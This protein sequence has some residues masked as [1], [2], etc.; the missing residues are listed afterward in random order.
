[1]NKEPLH[2]C[3][4]IDAFDGYL[5]GASV[6][7]QR[8]VE[9]LRL[10]GHRVSVVAAGKPA[11]DKT[12][13]AEYYPPMGRKHMHFPFGKPNDKVLSEVISQVDIVHVQLPFKLSKHAIRI[14][15]QKAKPCV[16]SFHVQAENYLYPFR[17]TAAWL[18]KLVYHYQIHTI[19]NRVDHVIC[20]SELGRQELNRHGLAKPATVIS[21][22]VDPM[23]KP[24]VVSDLKFKRDQFIIVTVGRLSREKQQELI[25]KAISNSP[26]RETIHLIVIGHG[27]RQKR[28]VQLARQLLSPSQFEFLTVVEPKQ[29]VDYYNAAKL[30]VH[31]SRI[32]LECMAAL[33]AIACAT[34]PLIANSPLSAAPQFAL[35]DRSLFEP[36]S[37]AQ[38]QQKIDAWIENP[39]ALE[40][41]AQQHLRHAK[42]FNIENS[43]SKLENVYR[44]CLYS[45]TTLFRV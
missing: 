3:M 23:F 42:Q 1:M 24:R 25:I 19:F 21:N 36:G 9:Q 37:V 15:R 11:A 26:H 28:L 16:A 32:E 40:E 8:F 22:G 5:N 30:F 39:A 38:L 41:S 20:P 29:L 14:A 35:D 31:A 18:A 10:R 33:E 17:L 12:V 13:V 34:T 4:V 45:K 44:S 43:L 6:S 27:A 2:I 7:T